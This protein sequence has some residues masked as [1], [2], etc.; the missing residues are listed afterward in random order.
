MHVFQ[1]LCATCGMCAQQRFKLFMPSAWGLIL[2]VHCL[3]T[4]RSTHLALMPVLPCNVMLPVTGNWRQHLLCDSVAL[5]LSSSA[6]QLRQL[7]IE[8]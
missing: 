8:T 3:H 4:S 6:Q 5:A 1:T 2:P 7:V